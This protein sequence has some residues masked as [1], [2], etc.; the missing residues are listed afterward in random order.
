MILKGTIYLGPNFLDGHGSFRSTV[1]VIAKIGM[2]PWVTGPKLGVLPSTKCISSLLLLWLEKNM[3]VFHKINVYKATAGPRVNDC[4][5]VDSLSSHLQCD[6]KN[7]VSGL[8][9]GQ[10]EIQRGWLTSLTWPDRTI[11]RKWPVDPQYRPRLFCAPFLQ[12]SE[13]VRVDRSAQVPH[14]MN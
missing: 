11:A 2:V 3:P 8:S 5:Q 12:E 10:L 6:E 9:P 1:S 7:N 13:R 4:P 14:Q